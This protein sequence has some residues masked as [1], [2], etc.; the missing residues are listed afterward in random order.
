MHGIENRDFA[1]CLRRAESTCHAAAV[2]NHRMP[3]SCGINVSCLRHANLTR[4]IRYG[5]HAE[6]RCSHLRT[7][8]GCTFQSIHT[9][10]QDSIS[11]QCLD[12]LCPKPLPSSWSHSGLMRAQDALRMVSSSRNKLLTIRWTTLRSKPSF[13]AFSFAIPSAIHS[14]LISIFCSSKAGFP[15]TFSNSNRT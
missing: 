9:V 6:N 15:R 2:Q 7:L 11:I 13:F 4:H 14:F 10:L 1:S 12:E 8:P 3:P 5:S